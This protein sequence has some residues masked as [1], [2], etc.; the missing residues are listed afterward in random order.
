MAASSQIGDSNT[1]NCDVIVLS[2]QTK[3]HEQ[4]LS[5]VT[6]LFDP[7][8]GWGSGRNALYFT[9]INRTQ[10][11]HYYI[12]LDDDAVLSFNEFTPPEMKKLQPFRAFEEWLLDYEPA[13]GVLNN[14]DHH[15]ASWT[16]ERRKQVCGITERSMVLPI[17]WF[18]GI[19]NSY[20]RKA[21]QHLFP[22]RVQYETISWWSL[23]RYMFTA[24][25]L[26]FRGQALMYVPVTSG[27]PAHRPYP[28]SLKNV[29]IYWR[30]YIETIQQEAPLVYR[31]RS[32]FDHFKQNLAVYDITSSTYCINVTRHQ[33]IVPFAH[34][35]R[36][37]KL[38]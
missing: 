6:Y 12:V 1:C 38:N 29:Q 32:L 24:V 18:D 36:E 23:H 2:Y 19:F 34:F 26:K 27:N 35:E 20:H 9:A 37:T 10:D 13:V 5:H 4:N 25:E 16:F 31:N 21:I 7:D 28:R 14:K 15:G 30:E 22:Y 11:Y 33:P 8:T 17:V 3:C